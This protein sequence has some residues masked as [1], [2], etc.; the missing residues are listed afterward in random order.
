MPAVGGPGIADTIPS[1]EDRMRRPHV[2][3]RS[4]PRARREAYQQPEGGDRQAARVTLRALPAMM[5]AA[6]AAGLTALL[7]LLAAARAEAERVDAGA[8]PGP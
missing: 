6:D 8:A 5:A 1:P 4:V 3:E 2:Y 7:G